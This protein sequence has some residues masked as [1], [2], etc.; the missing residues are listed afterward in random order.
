MRFAS[1]DKHVGRDVTRG[2]PSTIIRIPMFYT[3][4]STCGRTNE[5]LTFPVNCG[6][7]VYRCT[8]ETFYCPAMRDNAALT[9]ECPRPKWIQRVHARRICGKRIPS[10]FVFRGHAWNIESVQWRRSTRIRAKDPAELQ[11]SQFYDDIITKIYLFMSENE[12]TRSR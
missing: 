10:C 4:S 11:T 5:S 2:R 7:M 12:P 1:V 3:F 9:A 8:A 6:F